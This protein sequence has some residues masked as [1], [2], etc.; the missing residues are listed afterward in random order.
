MFYKNIKQFLLFSL[1]L[2]FVQIAIAQEVT[3]INQKGTKIN[4]VN[5]K[6]TTSATAPSNPF[7]GDVWYDSST[8]PSTV[9]IYDDV[10]GWLIME[11]KGTTGSVFFAGA[12][13]LPTENNSQL[14]WDSTNNRLGVGTN[15]PTNKF[16]VSGAIGAQGI[17]NSDGTENE[18]AFRFKDDTNT[19]MYS[20]A[21]DEIGF[22]VGG[23]EAM[24]IDEP[25]TGNTVVIV[26][27]T[28]ELQGK[29][30]DKSNSAGTAGQVLSSTATGTSWINSANG[31]ETK[32]TVAGINTISGAGTTASPYLITGTEVDGSITNEIN[33][34]VASS[35]NTLTVTDSGGAKSAPIVNSN[36]LSIT[37][38]A[39][40]S[41]VNG[42]ASTAITLP[43]ANG[44]ETKVTVAGINSI[45]GAGTTASPYLITGTEVDGSVTNEINTSVASSVNTLT[46]TDS[47]GAKSAPIVNSNALSITSGAIT[48]T[49]NGVAST[50]ITLPVANGS[51]TKV[52]AAGINSISG[53]GTT[54]SPY[55]ITGTEVDGSVT[56]EINTSVASSVNTLTVTDSGGAK[57]API[58]NS[59]ALSIASGAITS[60][61]NGVASTAIALP[62]A[63]GSET[64]V[65]AAGINAISGA[66]TTA[67][68]YLITGTE[69]DGSITNEI[70]TSVASSVNTLT[71]TDSGG[72]KS[73]P[74]VNSNA[75]S[76]ASGAITSTVNG[77]A[78]TAIALPIA[79]GSETKVT[80][81]GINA[82]SGA[83]TT[84]SPYLITGTEIDGSVTNELQTLSQSIGASATGDIT[85][86]N[87]G[88]TAKVV[89]ANA[90]NQITAG[91]DGG[92]YLSAVVIVVPKTA[93][94]TLVAADNGKV[95]TF[96]SAAAVTLTVPTGL[97]IGY[98]VSIY[99]TG[100]GNVTIAGGATILNR[101]SRFKTA[102]KDAGVGLIITATNTAHLTGDLKK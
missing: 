55:L 27:Q 82:I 23:V 25:T 98:N 61:V 47:G 51:E 69:V 66:G 13:G 88:G 20:P 79:D 56:N 91:T 42:V 46:V 57:S 71:V 93:N 9:K 63:D 24:K 59:N 99:Q 38:G 96:N 80:A 3:V 60:T 62:I 6:V 39:I 67:S 64:K 86:S 29:L 37:S 77:V 83:G 30:L 33:T 87:S 41:T 5:N 65:T 8:T 40:T 90:N 85:L 72:A 16:E 14:F 76:I 81:A 11:H 89:S 92:A 50:A 102:G 10:S 100:I 15:S 31:S 54:A 78:S 75:L 52:T 58:V 28:L 45:S 17:L 35:V 34:S 70:N 84:A 1:C 7:E 44:S 43:V 68:P 19:G 21:A 49:V 94:Y 95:F 97:T 22:T 74:I 101:L 48:S 4:V 18:P 73:A 53:A 12:N 36:T 26:N 2:F 32:V